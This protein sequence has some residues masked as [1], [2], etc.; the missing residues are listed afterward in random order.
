MYVN[1]RYRSANRPRSKEEIIRDKID[2]LK[3]RFLKPK[4]KRKKSFTRKKNLNLETIV[5]STMILSPGVIGFL[6]RGETKP[7]PKDA[8]VVEVVETPKVDTLTKVLET[9]KKDTT[10]TATPKPKAEEVSKQEAKQDKWEKY[11]KNESL[12]IA[13]IALVEDF[14]DE[15][16]FC[17]VAQTQAYGNIYNEDGTRITK[18]QKAI[19]RT[20]TAEF[21]QSVDSTKPIMQNIKEGTLKKGQQKPTA[22]LEKEVYPILDKYVKNP[23]KVES[24]VLLGT[25]LFMY[26]IGAPAFINS[27]YLKDL[28]DGK[29]GIELAKKMTGFRSIGGDFSKGLLKR[30]WVAGAFIVNSEIKVN[31]KSAGTFMSYLSKLKPASFY[32]EQE[33][34]K[35]YKEQ[36]KSLASHEY[37]TPKYDNETLIWFLKRHTDE[38]NNVGSILYKDT[39]KAI[40]KSSGQISLT[41]LNSHGKEY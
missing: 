1:P 15:V 35:L 12:F 5:L 36:M 41:A 39:R 30:E 3:S 13:G 29:R 18:D 26:N 31:D 37:Y 27:E 11:R 10:K 19:S 21:L 33:M 38:K 20:L 24:N 14:S 25:V 23:E 28:N 2:E 40:Q 4:K 9:E 22:Y 32:D 17:G 34:D 7:S 6:T 8:K 16:Y